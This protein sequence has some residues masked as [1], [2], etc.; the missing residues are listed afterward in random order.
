MAASDGVGG[1]QDDRDDDHGQAL[2]GELGQAVLQELLEVLDVARHP[3]H[4]HAGLLLGVEVESEPLE[5][6]EDADAKV[7]HHPGGQPAGHLH[8]G[9]LG[10]GGDPD[11]KPGREMRPQP[12]TAMSGWIIPSS[13]A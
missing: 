4:D 8:H 3:G 7:V 12:T 5:V 10:D 13:M 11:A 1:E 2:H 9:P 6:G